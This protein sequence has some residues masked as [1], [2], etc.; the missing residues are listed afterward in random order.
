MSKKISSVMM[1][2]AVE[3]LF[4]YEIERNGKVSSHSQLER[5]IVQE[6]TNYSAPNTARALQLVLQDIRNIEFS[7]TDDG[8]VDVAVE[9]EHRLRTEYRKFGFF[10]EDT[11]GGCSALSKNCHK[12]DYSVM[13]TT[14]EGVDAPIDLLEPVLMG[15]YDGGG[16]MLT[17]ETFASSFEMYASG[18]FKWLVR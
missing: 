7:I 6:L 1:K 15:L 18:F 11:G 10:V 17:H 3:T 4:N 5:W 14:T 12:G 2:R 13:V 9:A 8:S 16:N